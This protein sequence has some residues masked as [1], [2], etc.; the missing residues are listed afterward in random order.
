MERKNAPPHRDAA[1]LPET[2]AIEVLQKM[3]A[4]ELLPYLEQLVL[5]TAH[6]ISGW[7][8]MRL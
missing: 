1:P 4:H 8:W 3:A 6:K 5:D 7:P 2:A